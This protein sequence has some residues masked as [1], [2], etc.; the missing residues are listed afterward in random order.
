MGFCVLCIIS[1]KKLRFCLCTNYALAYKV[2]NEAVGAEDRA[3]PADD[4]RCAHTHEENT[5]DWVWRSN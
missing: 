1:I 3:H 2:G 4:T 5:D